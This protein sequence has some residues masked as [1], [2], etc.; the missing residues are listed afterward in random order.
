[1]SSTGG[2]ELFSSYEQDFNSIIESIKSKIEQQIPNQRG[3]KEFTIE[4]LTLSY[5]SICLEERKATIRA[6]EREIDESEEIV[7]N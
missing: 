6:V 7:F 4:T 2:S 5:A 1:M 3:G